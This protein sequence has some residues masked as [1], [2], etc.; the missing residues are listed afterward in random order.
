MYFE[1][2]GEGGDTVAGREYIHEVINIPKFCPAPDDDVCPIPEVIN[3]PT[4]NTS[5]MPSYL[6]HEVLAASM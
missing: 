4:N 1:G 5:L 2:T 3:T 6:T